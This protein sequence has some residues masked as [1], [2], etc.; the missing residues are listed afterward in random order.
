MGSID[1]KRI[2][3]ITIL[4]YSAKPVLDP[5]TMTGHGVVEMLKEL[6]ETAAI[7]ARTSP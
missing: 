1:L 7:S 2:N 5:Y 6:V 4:R 3:L